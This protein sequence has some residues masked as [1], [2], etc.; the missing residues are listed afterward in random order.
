MPGMVD[1][2]LGILSCSSCGA[3]QKDH[4]ELCREDPVRL[5]ELWD[6]LW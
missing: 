3:E 4:S 1:E 6:A 2:V 5:A